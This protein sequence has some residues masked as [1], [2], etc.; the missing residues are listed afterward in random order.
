MSLA[1]DPVP[2]VTVPHLN[3][4][5]GPTLVANLLKRQLKDAPEHVTIRADRMDRSADMIRR[6]ATDRRTQ[7]DS[8]SEAMPAD[9]TL[10]GCW[11]GLHRRV[12]GWTM[13]PHDRYPEAER[14]E[15]LLAT[16]F[17]H[18]LT[19]TKF[20]FRQEMQQSEAML[21]QIEKDGLEADIKALAGEP[22]LKEVR[23]AHAAYKKIIDGGP[24]G[25]TN[26]EVNIQDALQR[27]SS[28]IGDYALH[29]ISTA[30]EAK[31]ET[32]EAAM[33]ALKP[34]DDL[35]AEM[36]KKRA[37]KKPAAKPVEKPTA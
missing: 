24:K 21:H 6:A 20:G 13:L 18:G 5:S 7:I 37:N 36:A 33:E 1:I 31:P 8:P 19:F 15:K 10:D 16:L 27:L 12:D 14:A 17:P 2:Y 25:A 23:A 4:D 3:L 26:P 32:I 35:R 30:D 28:E 9:R 34:I 22:F 29:V 11:G